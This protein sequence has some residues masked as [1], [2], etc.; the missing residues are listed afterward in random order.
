MKIRLLGTGAN[1]GVPAF[2]CNCSHCNNAR[3]NREKNFRQNSCTLIE[4]ESTTILIDTPPQLSALLE[5]NQIDER[6]FSGVFLTHRH[7][8]HILGLRS[9]LQGSLK[10]GF[11]IRNPLPVF[12]GNSTFKTASGKFLF[13]KKTRSLPIE[14]ESYQ[15]KKIAPLDVIILG[16]LTITPVETG[17]LK[18][19]KYRDESF[20]YIVKNKRGLRV[21]YLMDAPKNLPE[22]TMS[23]LKKLKID[24]LI[25][26]CTFAETSPE[27]CHNDIKGNILLKKALKPSSMVVNH[28]G[29][30]NYSY[31][32]LRNILNKEGIK[33]AYDGM[34][35]DL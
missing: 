28:I 2:R 32:K 16:S 30:K 8:D 13:N 35:I 29:H 11:I 33:T 4:D 31:K 25:S 24:L 12:M 7:E 18:K 22:K 27:S 9:I 26:D 3:E 1:E 34:I 14:S 20:A 6:S 19:K 5:K 10:K 23:H 21:L 17:H 15:I